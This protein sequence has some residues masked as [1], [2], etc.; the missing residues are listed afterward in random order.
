M[1]YD[2]LT[3]RHNQE[4]VVQAL[5]SFY[6]KKESLKFQ[7]LNNFINLI[8]FNT[9]SGSKGHRKQRWLASRAKQFV[10]QHIH[11]P[12]I[13]LSISYP[14]LFVGGTL[15]RKFRTS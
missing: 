13:D 7:H 6:L 12:D 8:G 14:N 4:T 1:R 10:A 11:V 3:K 5:P 9:F 15:N 2:R